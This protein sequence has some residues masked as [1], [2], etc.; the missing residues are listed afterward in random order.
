MSDLLEVYKKI[1]TTLNETSRY[2]FIFSMQR[3]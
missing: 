1:P 3:F 2:K